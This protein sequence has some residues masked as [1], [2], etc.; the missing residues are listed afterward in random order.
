M[1]GSAPVCRSKILVAGGV[2]EESHE[3]LCGLDE[4][5]CSV[6]AIGH[7]LDLQQ[8]FNDEGMHFEGLLVWVTLDLAT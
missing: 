3:R 2:T 8:N 4:Y 6:V 5:A 1:Q 7:S